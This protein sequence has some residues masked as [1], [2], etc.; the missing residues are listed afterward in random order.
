M[1]N[2]STMLPPTPVPPDIREAVDAIIEKVGGSQ[3]EAV[4]QSL[5][6]GA[7]RYLAAMTLAQNRT[8]SRIRTLMAQFPPVVTPAQWKQAVKNSVRGKYDANR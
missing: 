4:R 1:K 7:G 5:R 6:F 3:A 2:T 8:S